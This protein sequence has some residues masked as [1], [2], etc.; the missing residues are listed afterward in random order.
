MTSTRVRP[1]TVRRAKQAGTIIF[2]L[3]VTLM[4]LMVFMGLAFDASY[5]YYYKR[6]MQ[7][8]AD[9][10]AIAGAQEL[11]RGASGAVT[12]SARQDT[13]LNRFTHGTDGVDVS[14]NNPPTSGP[15]AGNTSFVEVIISQPRPSWFMRLVGVNS[16]TVR[17]RAVAGLV[18]S[19]A[20]VYTL[21]TDVSNPNNGFFANGTTNSKFACGIVSNANFRAVGGGC[22]DVPAVGYSGDYVNASSSDPNCGPEGGTRAVPA[23][24]PMKQGY[25]LPSTAPC[26]HTNYKETAAATVTLTPGVYCGG[27]D[28]GGTLEMATFMPGTYVL[29]GGGM[30][31]GSSVRV[32]GDSVTF[33][34]TIP[35]SQTNKYDPISITS[36]A[37]VSLRAPTS[38]PYKALLFWQDPR[39]AWSANNGSIIGGGSGSVFEGILYFPTTDLT[40]SGNSSTSLTGGYTILIAYNLKVAGGS[41]VNADFS[42]IGGVSP[43]SKAAFTE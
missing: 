31:I 9:A 15:S 17:A 36:S 35:G 4:S 37:T 28:L 3:A 13:G 26:D 43:L 6:R 16:S 21:N 27:I 19:D 33:F 2:L 41:Q 11:L 8:A 1:L 24:D 14:V 38:G 23:V 34:N 18:G 5:L 12:A 10:G 30:R 29:V 25:S 42:S 40:Y 22:V 20:C 32:S 39:V 7:T